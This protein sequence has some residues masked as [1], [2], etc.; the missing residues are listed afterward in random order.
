MDELE[1]TGKITPG[2]RADL[3]RIGVGIVLR[4]GVTKADV[5]T[6]EGLKQALIDAQKIAYTDPKLGGAT[7]AHLL[8]VAESFGLADMVKSKGV[9]A[10]G[11]DDAAAK[12]ARG[13]ADLAM[14]F[15]SEIQ[16]GGAKMAAALPEGLQLWAIYS[17]AIPLA[18]KEP[19]LA[20]AFLAALSGPAMAPRWSA[21]GWRPVR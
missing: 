19:A 7:Y 9:F 15:I 17:A 5:A 16:A 4:D 8:K 21:A 3:G 1:K 13:E 14:V 18:S 11:G 10:T 6:P 20:G 2:S 12:V